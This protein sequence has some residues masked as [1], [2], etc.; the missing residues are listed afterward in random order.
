M[1]RKDFPEDR[2][3]FEEDVADVER[4]EDPRPL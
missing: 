1:G 2:H 3:P 4:V